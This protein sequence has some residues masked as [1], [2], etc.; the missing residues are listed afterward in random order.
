MTPIKLRKKAPFFCRAKKPGGAFV[1]FDRALREDEGS[2]C[3]EC[4]TAEKAAQKKFFDTPVE[5]GQNALGR[6]WN[7]CLPPCPSYYGPNECVC[8][9]GQKVSADISLEG[10]V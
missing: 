3:Q 7:S 2:V 9:N 1:H 6:P 5:R 8:G 4:A 10:L